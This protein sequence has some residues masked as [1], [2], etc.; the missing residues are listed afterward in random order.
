MRAS[1]TKAAHAMN[2]RAAEAIVSS[3][4]KPMKIFPISE[5]WSQVE[6]S[7]LLA[8]PATRARRRAAGG[9]AEAMRDGAA[10]ASRFVQRAIDVVELIGGDDL[11]FR[12]GLGVSRIVRARSA[13]Y[14]WLAPTWPGRSPAG[15]SE[16]AN[17]ALA[18]ATE[19]RDAAD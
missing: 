10:G 17:C 18:L 5:V 1:G 7:L 15:V 19:W 2:M 8:L 11:G 12:R 13:R 4:P 3:A 9:S 6:L 16:E 14:R